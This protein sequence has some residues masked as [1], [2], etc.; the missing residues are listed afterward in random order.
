MGI[1]LLGQT[2]VSVAIPGANRLES[3]LISTGTL[4][5]E[6]GFGKGGRIGAG[7]RGIT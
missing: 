7:G 3:F 6:Y 5:R 2:A 4:G 1:A